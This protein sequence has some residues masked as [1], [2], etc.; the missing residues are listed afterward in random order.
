MLLPLSVD[1]RLQ[2]PPEWIC[3]VP[4][5]P[6]SCPCSVLGSIRAGAGSVPFLPK[7]DSCSTVRMAQVPAGLLVTL[8]CG[9]APPLMSPCGHLHTQLTLL[10][11]QGSA[12][13]EGRG[14]L[15]RQHSQRQHLSREDSPDAAQGDVQGWACPSWLQLFPLGS[16][17]WGWAS[18]G[19]TKCQLGV[20]GPP[21]AG[22][23][24]PSASP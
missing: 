12:E 8:R 20:C 9:C 15:S 21:G 18:W 7:A 16:G 19:R 17:Q 10:W 13:P 6:G 23:G 4:S 1:L 24:H 3:S 5:V 22:C 14:G 2:G 11:P